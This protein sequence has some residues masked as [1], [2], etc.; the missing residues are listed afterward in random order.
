MFC[1]ILGQALHLQPLVQW[2][3]E[4]TAHLLS[5]LPVYSFTLAT[6]AWLAKDASSLAIIRELLILIRL[7]YDTVPRCRPTLSCSMTYD[8]LSKLYKLI[9]QVLLSVK[10]SRPVSDNLLDECSLISTQVSQCSVPSPHASQNACLIGALGV[11][12]S[13]ICVYGCG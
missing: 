10:E 8:A 7:W 13:I 11:F 4:L 3:C 12:I 5:S 1:S 2:V 6:G 9:S